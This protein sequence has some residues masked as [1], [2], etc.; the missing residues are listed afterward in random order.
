MPKTTTRK[1]ST[2]PKQPKPG[3]APVALAP[4]V[5]DTAVAVIAEAAAPATPAVAKPSANITR[6][7]ATIARGA[8]NF[9]SLSDRDTAYLGF[10][11]RLAATAPDGVLTVA[12]IVASGMRP[13][14]IGSNKPHDA[15]VI[16]RGVKAGLYA[17]HGSDGHAFIITAL[18]SSTKPSTEPIPAS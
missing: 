15:G 8:T 14:H 13:P 1:I 4:V 9:G 12:N 17:M 6:T 5:T 7:A 2:A 18:G 3:K 16:V 11:R 10:Y